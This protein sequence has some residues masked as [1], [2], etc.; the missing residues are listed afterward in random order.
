MSEQEK[1]I[2]KN[3]FLTVV[4]LSVESDDKTSK[5]IT[6]DRNATQTGSMIVPVTE[7]GKIILVEEYRH[8][9]KQTVIS[10]PKGAKDIESESFTEVAMRELAE[11][12]GGEARIYMTSAA[13]PYALPAFT[14]T[15]GKP[16]F[17]LGVSIT[18]KTD[19]EDGEDIKVYGEFSLSEIKKMLQSGEIN[20]CETCFV[21]W[22]FLSRLPDPRFL[23]ETVLSTGYIFGLICVWGADGT[24][25]T[26]SEM[27]LE[28]RDIDAWKKGKEK[29]SEILSLIPNAKS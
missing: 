14:Q 17:A 26:P 29:A 9:S 3:K 24:L 6:F 18:S 4:E 7:D 5:F 10:I 23:D 22:D 21:L 27:E 25:V 8:G 1:V 15:R 16:V 13:M 11:E 28:D 19:L 2:Y 12:I 20:D